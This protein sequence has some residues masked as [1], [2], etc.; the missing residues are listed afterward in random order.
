MYC[1]DNSATD[2]VR[3]FAYERAQFYEGKKSKSAECSRLISAGPK[4][5]SVGIVHP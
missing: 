5:G 1:L 4:E 2:R 3:G